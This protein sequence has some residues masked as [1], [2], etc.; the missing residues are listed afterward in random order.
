MDLEPLDWIGAFDPSAHSELLVAARHQ[1]AD[2]E[3]A[4]TDWLS[5]PVEK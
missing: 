5:A 2:A 4:G 3:R 1:L